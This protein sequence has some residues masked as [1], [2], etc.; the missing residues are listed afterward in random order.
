[1]EKQLTGYPSVDKP[2]LKYYSE[3]AINAPLPE[4]TIYE[5]L[6]ENNKD[7]PSD[8]AINYVGRKITYKELFENI[9]KTAAAFLR[10]G[11]QEKEIV[12]IAL[13]SIPEALYCVYA[14]NKIGA[15]ANMIHPL[16]G[17][18]ETINYINEVR[19]RIVVIFDGNYETIADDIKKTSVEKV[20]V[21]SPADSLPFVLNI[22]YNLK[23]K[24]R[25]Y[26]GSLFQTWKK[27]IL[28]GAGT[29]VKA[30]K[31]DCH[32]VAIISHTGGTTGEPKGCMISDYNTIAEVWQVGK[33][34]NPSRQEC[35]L[36]VLP[37]FVNYSL[38]NGM[39]EPLSF[40]MQLVLIPKYEPLK[41]AKYVKKYGVNHVNT[42]PAYCEALLQ[43]PDVEKYD[44]STLKY[45]VYGGE[46]MTEETEIAVN[47]LLKKC[48]C[49]YTLKKGLG[50]TEATSAASAT[51]DSV[52]NF[53]SVGI[54]FP[55][56]IIKTVDADSCEEK[57]YGEEGEICISGP[58]VMQGYYNNPEATNDLIRKHKD[59][60]RWIH[61]GDLGYINEDGVIF[62]TGRIKR[63]VMTRGED[64]QVTKFFPDR[65]ERKI[66]SDPSVELCCVIGVPDESRI[67]YPKAII[68]LKD[69]AENGEEIA[70]RIRKTCKQSLPGYMVPDE[71]EF[72]AELPRTSRGKVD[73]RALE[74]QVTQQK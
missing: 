66:N 49:K 24:R 73:Y 68:V 33:T 35:M 22:A 74:E 65:I 13:P 1:M 34:M 54:P 72:R 42:I 41:F 39:F 7:Y 5:Y 26:N 60:R 37:P 71:I 53:E 64:G 21:A 59:G 17:K 28:E 12:T 11:V 50:M 44:L 20:I 9:D 4:C 29:A 43:A 58:T 70:Q 36:A 23:V 31:K 27:F 32:E 67:N 38:T 25:T 3:E 57:R 14:L 10:I 69:N 40:G 30:V 15:V 2:W 45:V 46:G 16:A 19:S 48:G 61:T 47:A 6:V 62:V 56:M 18:D 63:I 8:I 52:N 51:F 55:K